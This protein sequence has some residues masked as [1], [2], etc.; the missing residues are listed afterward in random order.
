LN[1]KNSTQNAP[2]LAFLNSKNE[3]FSG[4]AHNPSPDPTSS[5]K[6]DT[7]SPNLT[8]LSAFGVTVLPSKL[9]SR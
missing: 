6:G 4:E 8:P 1:C 5:G 2:K 9:V 3:K 7:S